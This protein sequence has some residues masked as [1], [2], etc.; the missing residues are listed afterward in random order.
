MTDDNFVKWLKR[1]SGLNLLYFDRLY[2][3]RNSGDKGDSLFN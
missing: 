2:E 1:E 3:V